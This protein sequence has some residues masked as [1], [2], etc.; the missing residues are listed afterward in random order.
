MPAL[1]GAV[2]LALASTA[3]A[4]DDPQPVDM[5]HNV[6]NAPA[7]VAGAVFGTG[8]PVK[9]GTAIS[10]TP[11]QTAANANTDCEDNGPHRRPR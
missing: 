3:L 11:A 9:T 1:G 8:P 10:T 4:N 7:P 2:L 6:I 5:T